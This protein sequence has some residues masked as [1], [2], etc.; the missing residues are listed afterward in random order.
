MTRMSL[1]FR[2]LASRNLVSPLAAAALGAIALA[3]CASPA[4]YAPRLHGE[5]TGYTD[6]ELT[7]TRYQITFIGNSV[8][9]QETVET[10]LL[11]RAAEVTRAAG[12]NNFVFDTRN[13][14]THTTYHALAP[15]PSGPWYN[16]YWGGWGIAYQ[17]SMDVIARIRYQAYAEIVLLTPEQAAQ[18][19]RAINAAQV[20]EHLGPDAVPPDAVHGHR[21]L[22]PPPPPPA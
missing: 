22:P 6:R 3:G 10:Y 17:P 7:P 20:I 11:L 13:T 21:P 8:T 12:Y 15:M 19:P 4:P 5:R 18:R 1:F 9:S 14:R 2:S 16:P